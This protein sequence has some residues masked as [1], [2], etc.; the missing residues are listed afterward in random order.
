[1][2]QKL[3]LH[4]NSLTTMFRLLMHCQVKY[5]PIIQFSRGLATIDLTNGQEIIIFCLKL[6]LWLLIRQ[7][8]LV[9]LIRL[10][11]WQKWNSKKKKKTLEIIQLLHLNSEHSG[12]SL[13]IFSA[14]ET[15]AA[16]INSSTIWFASRIWYIPE[17][18]RRPLD[19]IFS[20][21]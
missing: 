13:R 7:W 4:H 5:Y 3:I 21:L 8:P 15:F 14:T 1:M 20:L 19:M 10:K 17:E 9:L 18:T 12:N 6:I 16:S 11:R 2:K